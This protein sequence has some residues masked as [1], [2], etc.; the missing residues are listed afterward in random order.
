MEAR[1]EPELM[2]RRERLAR[3]PEADGSPPVRPVPF[4]ESVPPSPRPEAERAGADDET[5][6]VRLLPGPVP[7]PVAGGVRVRAAREARRVG[8]VRSGLAPRARPRPAG[9]AGAGD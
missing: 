4:V 5:A 2:D 1:L 9:P 7:E 3:V 6:V 8:V